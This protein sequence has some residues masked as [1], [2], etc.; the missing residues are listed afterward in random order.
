MD[1][2]K[3]IESLRDEAMFQRSRFSRDVIASELES[4]AT[5]IETLLAERDAAVN[6]LAAYEDTG[7]E[8]EEVKEFLE[9][10]ESRF[11]LWINKRYGIPAMKF[12]DIMQA[13]KYGRLVVLPCSLHQPLYILKNGEIHRNYGCQWHFTDKESQTFGTLSLYGEFVNLDD[14]GKTVFLTREEAEAAL[15]KREEADN[16][17]D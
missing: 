5:A 6:S 14:F 10:V 1:Y 4:A 7:L 16:E 11:V 3:F 8:P 2:K 13:E 12:M 15:K 9:D 17:T